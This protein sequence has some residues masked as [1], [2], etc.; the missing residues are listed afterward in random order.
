M[1]DEKLWLICMAATFVPWGFIMKF[2]SLDAQ[3]VGL[4]VQLIGLATMVLCRKRIWG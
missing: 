4:C 1:K 2:V 3:N